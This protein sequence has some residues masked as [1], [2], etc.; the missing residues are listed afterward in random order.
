MMKVTA[1][2]LGLYSFIITLGSLA[3]MILFLFVIMM[4]QIHLMA[5]TSSVSPRVI[6]ESNFTGG[7][8]LHTKASNGN[9]QLS[10]LLN[11]SGSVNNN[12]TDLALT[13]IMDEGPTKGSAYATGMD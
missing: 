4:V 1:N 11:E 7:L 8:T 12:S 6:S 9:N 3:I 2:V 10:L 13:L 5:G